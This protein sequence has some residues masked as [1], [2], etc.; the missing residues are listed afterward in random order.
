MKKGFQLFRDVPLR[1]SGVIKIIWTRLYIVAIVLFLAMVSACTP[2]S[3]PVPS[4]TRFQSQSD[5]EF[6]TPTAET[7]TQTEAVEYTFTPEPTATARPTPT[8]TET[9]EPTLTP[10]PT[11]VLLIGAGDIAVCGEDQDELTSAILERYPEA[12]IF[13]AGD[14]TYDTGRA[15]EYQNCY[16]PSWGRFKDRTRPSP[17]NHDYM[18]DQGAPYFA[19]FGAQAGEPGKGFYSYDLGDW[20]IVVLNSNCNDIACG[21]TSA[22]VEWLRADLAASDKACTL[23]YWHHPR[24]SSGLAGNSGWISPFW[25]ALYEAGAEIVINGHD[26]NYERFAPQDPDANRDPRGIRAFVVGTGGAYQRR[27][28]EIQ[29]NSEVRQTG[30]FGVILFSLYPDRYE[31][32]FVGIEGETF[33]DSGEGSCH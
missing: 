28:G 1:S 13:T 12:A 21:N 33:T 22:Q 29:P 18:T 31:W 6:F 7:L 16:G 8:P 32:Q 4:P 26:H 24:F 15:V 11:P 14:N 9:T 20:H 25:R 19:Y 27:F 5:V 17:G 23:A 10:T 3:M 30:S 2:F